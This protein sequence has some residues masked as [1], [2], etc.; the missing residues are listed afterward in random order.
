M[1]KFKIYARSILI[2]VVLGAVIGFFTSSSNDY[3]SLQR[4]FLAPPGFIFPIVWTILYSLMGVSYG[5]LKSNNLTDEKIDFIYYIQLGVNALW[6]IFFFIFK[7][8][9]F[10]FLWIILLII[11]VVLM[12]IKFYNKNKLAGLLQLPYLLW[13]LFA[14]YLNI[15][16]YILNR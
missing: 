7:W 14:S 10:S 12:I 4:P 11:L 9:L 6:S 3:S 2:P 8:R 16:T 5:I 1:E 13:L 15:A